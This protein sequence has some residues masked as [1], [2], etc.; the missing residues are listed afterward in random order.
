VHILHDQAICAHPVRPSCLCTSYA[1]K[2]S[3]RHPARPSSLCLA[4]F[5]DL[6]V[7]VSPTG[8]WFAAVA[9]VWG[10]GFGAGFG[11]WFGV[12]MVQI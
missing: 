11:V 12:G 1:T 9:C 3:V 6:V 7:V 8:V 2:L 10:L 4:R 5:H